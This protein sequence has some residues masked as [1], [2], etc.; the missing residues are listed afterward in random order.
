VVAGLLVFHVFCDIRTIPETQRC[1]ADTLTILTFISSCA[2][3]YSGKTLANYVYAVRAWH[4]LHGQPWKMQHEELKAA[5][6]GA[7]VLTP[8]SSKRAKREP[9]TI[10]LILSI[11][12]HLDL[13]SPLDAAVYAC[14]TSTFYS[15]SRLGELT[16]NALKA[17]RPDKHVKR[18]DVTLD[19]EDRNGLCVT[20]IFLPRTKVSSSGEDI[21]WAQQADATDPKTALL[22]H[23][24]VND[25]APGQH[26]FAWKHS[27]GSRPLTHRAFL[28]RIEEIAKNIGITNV[29]GHGLRI[30]GTLEYLLR[31]IPFDVVKS[32]GR[33][34]SDSFT[35]YLRKHAMIMAPYIQDS[36]VLE[37]FTRYT[38]PPL[39]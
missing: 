38:M 10:D 37:P 27:N 9:F 15:L 4:T 7:M 5:L 23:F 18:S 36:P 35:L 21:Y 13:I 25:P 3:S 29:K 24:A 2:G 8:A 16:V 22:H 30:G 20:K 19:M 11:R 34:S 31:G 1:P 39:R 14:L 32:M 33:W 28:K 6:D 17:F 12:S 26:L